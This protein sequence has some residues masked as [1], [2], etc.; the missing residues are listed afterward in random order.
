MLSKRVI[1][2]LLA[3][4]LFSGQLDAQE[5]SIQDLEFLI[6]TWQVREDIKDRNWW[7][8]ATRVVRYVLDSTFIEIDASAKSSSGKERTYRWYIHFNDKKQQFEMVSMFSNW[9]KVQYDL[10]D[11][12]PETRKLTISH[13]P[14]PNSEVYHERFGEMTFTDDFSSYEWKGENKYGDPEDP[15]IWRYLE[16]GKR[17]R[18]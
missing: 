18:K 16:K 9:H 12:D 4:L 10:L 2:A 7:E 14:D 8:E 3:L 17:T 11:W 13:A 15:G 5:K 1:V 6:G